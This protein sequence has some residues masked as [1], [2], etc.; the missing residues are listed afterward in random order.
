[1]KL[2]QKGNIFLG[3]IVTFII[4]SMIYFLIVPEA[5]NRA[6]KNNPQPSELAKQ[7]SESNNLPLPEQPKQAYDGSFSWTNKVDITENPF[8]NPEADLS[9]TFK[10]PERK[11]VPQDT[12]L[13]T[14]THEIIEVSNV[15]KDT[16]T[17]YDFPRE[18]GYLDGF[19]YKFDK[20]S[21]LLTV[22]AEATKTDI[23]IYLFRLNNIQKTEKHSPLFARAIFIKHGESF[24]VND[25]ESGIYS[26]RWL[27]LN[28]GNAYEYPK[29]EIYQDN[30]FKYNRYFK[31]N[32]TKTKS[33]KTIPLSSFYSN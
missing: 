17:G 19:P 2:Y 15:F 29:F 21:L 4:I 26:L 1:M 18:S 10:F 33:F 27:E 32:G 24:V 9:N 30:K 3:F 12:Q 22:N 7:I 11:K 8:G 14:P 25:L 31:F 6:D 5:K 23:M 28:S 20:G 16:P 13:T